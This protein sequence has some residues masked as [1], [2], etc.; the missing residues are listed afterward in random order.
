MPTSSTPSMPSRTR[1]TT[2]RTITRR[3]RTDPRLTGGRRDQGHGAGRRALRPDPLLPY[4]PRRR[5]MVP[6]RDPK[7]HD[8]AQLSI[9]G[10]GVSYGATDLLKDVTFTV[11][12]GE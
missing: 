5:G 1:I 11:E 8:V 10:V 7:G 12:A 3:G 9:G 2:A 6:G 4:S